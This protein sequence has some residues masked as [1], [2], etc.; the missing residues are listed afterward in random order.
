MLRFNIK[1]AFK[2]LIHSPLLAVVN[3]VGLA[4]AMVCVLF[5][6]LWLRSELS[7]DKHIP[8]Y[9][10]LY[11]ITVE[12]NNPKY[13][14]H[15]HFARPYQSWLTD[16]KVNFPEIEEEVRIFRNENYNLKYL[17]KVFQCRFHQ[18]DKQFLRM[19]DVKLLQGNADNALVDMHESI[20]NVRHFR[21]NHE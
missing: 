13:N 21:I 18:V 3:I 8:N 12:V 17:E 9:E 5:I 10:R 6:A 14:Q 16:L 15:S 7:Y 4:L 1:I 20:L 2:N 19:F 11:R